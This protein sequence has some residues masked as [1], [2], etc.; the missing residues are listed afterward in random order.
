M[1]KRLFVPF[2]IFESLAWKELLKKG[3]AAAMHVFIVIFFKQD[4]KRVSGRK[5]KKKVYACTNPDELTCSYT[6]AEKKYGLTQP[7][8]TRAIDELL[9][10]GFITIKHLG[11]GRE[12]DKTTFSLSENYQLWKPGTVFSTR[13]SDPVQR[14]FCSPKRTPKTLE[15]PISKVFAKCKKEK[16]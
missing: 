12:K 10:M 13:R 1:G 15:K 7:R 5:D 2:E 8:L 9:T 6:E 4:M 14:G 3:S 11:G 16:L